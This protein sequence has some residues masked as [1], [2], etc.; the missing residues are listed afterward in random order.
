MRFKIE[1]EIVEG[2]RISQNYHSHILMLL[3]T[4]LRKYEDVF[5]NFFGKNA[6]KK[7]TWA[8]YFP[9]TKFQNN[10]IIFTKDKKSFIINFSVLENSDSINIYNAFINI[11]F[12]ELKLNETTKIKVIKVTAIPTNS[13]QENT[14]IAKVMSP[15]I[16]RDHN[17]ETG[18]DIYYNGKEQKFTE[19]I[20]RNLYFQ[21]KDEYGEYVKKDIESLVIGTVGLKKVV[22]KFYGKSIDASIGLICLEGKKYLLDYIYNGGFGSLTGSGFGYLEKM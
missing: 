18:K 6:K 10:E 16:C 13:I 4:G 21:L 19:V 9:N 5:E 12:K 3:K 8:V 17:Q 7:Y 1:C 20:K 15:I 11:K 14:L 2:D 22:V